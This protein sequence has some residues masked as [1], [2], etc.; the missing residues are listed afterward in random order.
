MNFFVCIRLRLSIYALSNIHL[1]R[2]GFF[3]KILLMLS[4]DINLN[5][6]PVHGIQSENLL[7]LLSFMIVIFLETT[8]TVIQIA[9]AKMRAGINGMSLKKEECILF[10]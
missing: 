5:P 6:G 7:H 1:D 8:F 9:L 4:W 10:T 3:C 2:Y